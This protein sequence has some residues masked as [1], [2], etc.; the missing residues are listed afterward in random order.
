MYKNGYYDIIHNYTLVI[1]KDGNNIITEGGTSYS[2]KPAYTRHPFILAK[3]VQDGISVL[4]D[5]ENFFNETFGVVVYGS[6]G[7]SMW[8]NA[9]KVKEGSGKSFDFAEFSKTMSLVL[10]AVKS[11]AEN[12]QKDGD[13]NGQK[14]AKYLDRA[15]KIAKYMKE[16][17]SGGS[18]ERKPIGVTC[19]NSCCEGDTIPWEERN[20]GHNV[21]D[22]IYEEKK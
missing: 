12:Q 18:T 2:S 20:N 13:F 14:A 11:R 6:E 9:R 21:N 7:S 1:D 8:T 17:P 19:K 5:F 22:T 4:D 15:R 3:W 16:N 10:T